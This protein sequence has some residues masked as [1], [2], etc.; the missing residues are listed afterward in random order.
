MSRSKKSLRTKP[1]HMNGKA[2]ADSAAQVSEAIV[3][4]QQGKLAQAK[5]AYRD[6]LAHNPGSFDA[7]HLLGVVELQMLNT[8]Q[9]AT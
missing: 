5:Q 2:P 8:A 6:V 3:L 4:H 1:K 9:G 7:L